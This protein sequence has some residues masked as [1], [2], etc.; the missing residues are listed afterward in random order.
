[1]NCNLCGEFPSIR[2]HLTHSGKSKQF[3]RLVDSATGELVVSADLTP[4]ATKRIIKE[5]ARFG[6][7]LAMAI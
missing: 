4:A 1:M 6:Y 3:I 7:E 2:L 5:Y